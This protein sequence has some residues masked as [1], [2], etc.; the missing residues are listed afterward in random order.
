VSVHSYSRCW[1]HLTWAT[2]KPRLMLP[3]A[4]GAKTSG[5]SYDYSEVSLNRKGG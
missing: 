3:K 5:F 4:A 1:L 2:M